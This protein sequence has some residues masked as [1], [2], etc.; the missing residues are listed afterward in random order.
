M[1]KTIDFVGDFKIGLR[2]GRHTASPSI[3]NGQKALIFEV[4]HVLPVR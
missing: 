2:F 4:I 3:R 1:P